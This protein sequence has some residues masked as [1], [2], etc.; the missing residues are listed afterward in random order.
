MSR[1][2]L[3]KEKYNMYSSSNKMSPGNEIELNPLFKEIKRLREW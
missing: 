3:R 2:K 1:I